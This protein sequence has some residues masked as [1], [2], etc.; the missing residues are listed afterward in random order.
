[1]RPLRNWLEPRILAAVAIATGSLWAFIEIADEVHENETHGIDKAILL[2][3]RSPGDPA[4]LLGPPWLQETV[5][6][7]TAL[8]SPVILSLLV[9]VTVVFLLLSGQRRTA[10]FVLG[11][12][13]GG[14]ILVTALKLLYARP[15]PDLV[16]HA[17]EVFS[18]SFPS[19]HALQAAVVYFTLAALV[20]RVLPARRPKLFLLV[21]AAVLTAAA[22]ISRIYLGVHWPS[23][24]LGGWAAGAAWALACWLLAQFRHLGREG[25]S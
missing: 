15:R 13:G 7:L 24:V 11:A 18:P 22:G 23:D 14:A 8:G 16:P 21:V 10:L 4:Q 19:G 9:V 6:D 17:M 1:M 12:T 5:R 3:L 20:A 2:A 25:G